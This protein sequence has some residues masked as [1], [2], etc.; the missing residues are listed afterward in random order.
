LWIAL[1]GYLPYWLSPHGAIRYLVPVYPIIGFALALLLWS[2]GEQARQSTRRWLS[3]VVALK[4]VAVVFLFPYYQSHYRGEN[5]ATAAR[6]IVERA[7]GHPLYTA[8]DT[9]SGL[10][11][12]GYID[13]YWRRADPIQWPPKDWTTGFVIAE[14]AD[15]AVGKISARYKL[16]GDELFLLCRGDACGTAVR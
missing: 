10:S 4:F 8:S 12:A 6:D 2:A 15:S 16:G 11:V 7:S 3:G 13:A 5:Y 1:L 9:A 14:E